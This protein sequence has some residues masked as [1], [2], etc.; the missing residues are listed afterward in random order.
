MGSDGTITFDDAKLLFRNFAG[1]EGP[2]NREGDR[3]FNVVIPEDLAPVLLADGWNVK[4]LDP[5]EDGGVPTK[6]MKVSVSFKGRPPHIMLITSKGRTPIG[7]N[8]IEMLD[9][10]DI[11]RVDLIVRPYHWAVRGSTGISAYLKTMFVTMEEDE[12]MQ[13]YANVPDA[14]DWNAV[15][16]GEVVSE[17]RAIE[18]G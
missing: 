8:E 18:R 12:L 3:N 13:R 17:R 15:I 10:I 7:V 11:A 4:T 14:I 6:C 5:R 9:W 16:D 2:Y 1:A